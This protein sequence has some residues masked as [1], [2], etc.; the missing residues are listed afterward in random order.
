MNSP[1]EEAVNWLQVLTK[2]YVKDGQLALPRVEP[3]RN[4][5]MLQLGIYWVPDDSEVPASTEGSFVCDNGAAEKLLNISE[6][7][8]SAFD[9]CKEIAAHQLATGQELLPALRTFSALFMTGLIKRPK[10]TRRSVTWLRNM[11]LLSMAK[12]TEARFDLNLTR[13]DEQR[14]QESACDAVVVALERNGHHRSYRSIKE[15]CVGTG[16]E[17]KELRRDF[18]AWVEA[19]RVAIERDPIAAELFPRTWLG[20]GLK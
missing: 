7:D 1:F 4:I 17:N 19:T 20:V 6:S 15:L 3:A 5:H 11:F 14:I 9:L 8:A 16:P 2:E 12:I 13:G 10:T 18:I